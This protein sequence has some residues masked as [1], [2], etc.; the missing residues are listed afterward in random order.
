MSSLLVGDSTGGV[1]GSVINPATIRKTVRASTAS[2]E[3]L[4]LTSPA[5]PLAEGIPRGGHSSASA[6]GNPATYRKSLRASTA[7]VAALQSISP[8]GLASEATLDS[9]TRIAFALAAGA[10]PDVVSW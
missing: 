9:A 5:F 7:S 10:L 3:L 8:T 6:T 4:Q 1:Q 2:T